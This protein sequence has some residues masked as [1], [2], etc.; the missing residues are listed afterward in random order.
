M[1]VSLKKVMARQD[2]TVLHPVI[3]CD[4]QFAFSN[5]GWPPGGGGWHV[6]LI[7]ENVTFPPCSLLKYPIVPKNCL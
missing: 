1:K 3:R 7:P 4:E 2:N 5:L 6:P